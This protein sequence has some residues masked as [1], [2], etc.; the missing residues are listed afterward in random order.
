MV[1]RAIITVTSIKYANKPNDR[2]P[3][4]QI[5]PLRCSVKYILAKSSVIYECSNV[6]FA[7]DITRRDIARA[8]QVTR[9][10]GRVTWMT[11]L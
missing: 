6:V 4:C 7:S 5:Y 2:Q 10:K 8:S 1:H 9:V 3:R 11:L